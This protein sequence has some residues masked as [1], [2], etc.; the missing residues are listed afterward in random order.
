MKPPQALSQAPAQA[1]R[2]GQ[3][4][5][6]RDGQTQPDRLPFPASEELSIP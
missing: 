3:Y 5:A 6:H 1:H 4:Q 2:N